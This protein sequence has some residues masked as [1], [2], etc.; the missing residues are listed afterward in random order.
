MRAL[1]FLARDLDHRNVSADAPRMHFWISRAMERA[2]ISASTIAARCSAN[3]RHSTGRI[4]LAGAALMA[5][6]AAQQPVSTVRSA[7]YV[8]GVS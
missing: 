1:V 6:D 5:F 4:D 3:S 2:V 8:I 7:K